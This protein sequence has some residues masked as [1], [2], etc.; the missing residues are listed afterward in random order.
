[1]KIA[2]L[3]PTPPYN[4]PLMLDLLSR[5]HVAVDLSRNDFSEYWRTLRLGT[6]LALVRV[7][8]SGTIDAPQLDVHL[9]AASGAVN[10]TAIVNQLRQILSVEVDNRAFYAYARGDRQLWEIIAPLVGI[11]EV[12]SASAFEALATTIIEQQISLRAA[13]RALR[14]L[15]QWAGDHLP[16]EGE[17]YYAFPTA[18]QIAA[19]TID[20]L[21]PLKITFKRMAL[22][23]EVA[24]RDA[25]GE[26]RLDELCAQP[27]A[28]HTLQ[29]IKGIGHWSAA[30]TLIR[31]R[32]DSNQVLHNDVALQAAVNTAFF[33]KTGRAAPETVMEVFKRYGEFGGLAAYHTVMRRVLDYF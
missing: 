19:A 25:S 22:L 5:Y 10:H 1:M 30:L 3:H 27:D 13:H 16:H 28:Y 18:A 31:T 33:G 14:W 23:I 8:N 32:G 4:F 11:R 20:D 9:M 12:R 29:R 17:A 21:R 2:T 24:Q 6:S 26:L 7:V 15:A